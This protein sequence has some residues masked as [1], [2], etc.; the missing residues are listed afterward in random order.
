MIERRIFENISFDYLPDE[1]DSKMYTLEN[2]DATL[3]FYSS[4]P[5]K[6]L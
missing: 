1:V 4:F 2:P 3:N 6:K 5:G